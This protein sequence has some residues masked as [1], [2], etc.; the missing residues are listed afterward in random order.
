[1][2]LTK[3]ELVELVESIRDLNTSDFEHEE[4]LHLF[5]GNVPNQDKANSLLRNN[6]LTSEEVVEKSLSYKSRFVAPKLKKLNYE[7]LI[8][9]VRVICNSTYGSLSETYYIDKLI[10]LFEFNVLHPEASGLIFHHDPEL[11]PEE[12]VEKALAYKQIIT[13]PPPPKTKKEVSKKKS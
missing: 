10:E 8:D 1:M 5:L 2:T 6:Q 9:V 4:A 7:E 3:N 12:I 13:P 11:T